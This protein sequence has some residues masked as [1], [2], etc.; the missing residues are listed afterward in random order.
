MLCKVTTDLPDK[1]TH[2]QQAR[3]TVGVDLGVKH[4]VALS[5]PLTPDDPTTFFLTNPRHV[6]R[7][8]K[9][10]AKAQRAL[11]RTQKGS[12][13]RVKARHPCGPPPPRS[14][15]TPRHHTP[16]ETAHDPVRRRRDR[17]PQ[18]RGHDQLRSWHHSGTRE[19]SEAEG[20]P[21]PVHPGHRPPA[22]CAASSPTRRPGTAPNSRSWTAG[23]R[24]ARPARPA[25]GK[26]HA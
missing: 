13:R 6:R 10:L 19:E 2:H 21:Q 24:P 20:R 22:S 3:G 23:G 7:A 12:A 26:T 4:L 11:S 17:G 5:Q 14:L 1:P 16:H 25:H 18:R 15:R 8:E 9:R